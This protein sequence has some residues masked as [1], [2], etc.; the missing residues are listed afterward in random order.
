MPNIYDV[1]EDYQAQLLSQD[2]EAQSMLGRAYMRA[3]EEIQTRVADLSSKLL[4][5]ELSDQSAKVSWL[6]ERERLTVLG[7]QIK[8]VLARYNLQA[9]STVVYNQL[10]SQDLAQQAFLDQ[11]RTASG[12]H[13]SLSDLPEAAIS[14]QVGFLSDG[15]PLSELL[16]SMGTDLSYKIR[17]ALVSSVATGINPRQLAYNI[18]RVAGGNLA[19]ILTIARTETMRSYR[20][21]SYQS[22]QQHADIL[23]GWKW[24]SALQLRTCAV[25]W[26]MHGTVHPLSE[27]FASHPNCRCTMIPMVKGFPD[28]PRATGEQAFNDLDPQ[29]KR[30]VLGD[31]KYEKYRTG[32]IRLSDLVEVGRSPKWGSYRIEKPLSSLP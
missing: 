24:K 6:Y 23:G 2:R 14:Q 17:D 27:R 26:A 19:R 30:K 9:T 13:I 1:T 11:I 7:M 12:I 5:A 15:S 16:D 25:C 4:D 22:Y 8:D 29:S 21:S 10:M 28:I 3:L 20:E 18:R 32:Q 31:A